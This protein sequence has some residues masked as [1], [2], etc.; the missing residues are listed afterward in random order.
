MTAICSEVL[1]GSATFSP[2]TS[3]PVYPTALACEN[4]LADKL[5]SIATAQLADDGY[6]AKVGGY[7]DP[8]LRSLVDDGWSVL[9]RIN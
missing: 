9:A 2:H 3:T 5:G 6:G 4:T 8:E 1:Q 7:S